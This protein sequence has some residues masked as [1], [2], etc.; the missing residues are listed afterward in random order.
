MPGEVKYQSNPV[1]SYK[2]EGDEGAVLYNPDTDKCVIIN[3]VGSVIWR[4]LEE[5]R[6]LAEIITMLSEEFSGV[7]REQAQEDFE[8]FVN[9]FEEGFIDAIS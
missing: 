5:P 4:Y 2:D 7:D 3:S 6:M 1:I 8:K 9:N